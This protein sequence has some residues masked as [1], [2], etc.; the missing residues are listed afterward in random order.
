MAKNKKEDKL[1]THNN[2]I[3]LSLLAVI[4]I[5]FSLALLFIAVRSEAGVCGDSTPPGYCSLSKPYYCESGILVEKAS[6][7][8]CSE[9]SSV[10]GEFC[11]SV[12]Q[13][14]P[15]AV[16][17][18]YI[19]NGEENLIEF[20]VY[21]GLFDY[22]SNL[23]R[24]I[25]FDTGESPSRLDFKLNAI[26][27]P[28]QRELLLPLVKKIQNSTSDKE[29]QARIAISLV[30]NIEYGF[31]NKT[32]DFLGEAL[33]YSRYPYEV[34]YES[35]GI[36][37][38]KSELLVFL[39]RELGYKTAFFYYSAEN[40]EAVGIGCPIEE[41]YGNSGYCFVETTGPS[42][43]TDDS[44]EYVGGI[45]LVSEP[46]IIPISEGESLGRGLPEY[47]DAEVVKKIRQGSPVILSNYKFD[48][49]KTRYGLIEEYNLA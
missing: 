27:E 48:L 39:L 18:N 5:G 15:R 12:Y 14:E 28:W 7:C 19:L 10:E 11:T 20:E 45:T 2:I 26:D 46:E 49:L 38:E 8:G 17:L 22:L 16:F 37:G 24:V 23:S 36:C 43:I 33:N 9:L 32:V 13:T 25:S 42:I 21:G 31:S 29:D 4:I 41:S 34:L 6:I 35:Q 44:I 47:K 40:H 30:Q 3:F 1:Q